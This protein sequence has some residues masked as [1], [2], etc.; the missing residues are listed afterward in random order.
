MAGSATA[1][2]GVLTGRVLDDQK[3]PLV[4]AN[5]FLLELNTG[6]VTDAEGE[7][8]IV[9]LPPGRYTLLVSFIGFAQIKQQVEIAEGQTRREDFILQPSVLELGELTVMGE[10]LKG[11]AKALNQQMSDDRIAVVVSADQLVRFPDQNIGDALKRLSAVTV[12]YDQGEARYAGI[13]G[14]DPRLNSVALDGERLPSPDA[15]TRAVQLDMISTDLIQSVEV[16]K[17]NTPD[18]DGDAIGGTVNLLTRPAV[19]SRRFNLSLGSGYDFLTGRG[20][21]NGSTTVGRRF[22]NEKLGLSLSGSIN[23]RRL[24]AHNSEGIWSVDKKGGIYASQWDI[25]RY[26]VRRLR[27]GVT[28]AADYRPNDENRFFL[29]LLL[30]Q[31]DDWE[32]RQRLRF[33]ME[34]PG[35]NDIAERSQ[36]YR[37][38]KGGN[39][40]QDNARL[41]QQRLLGFRL[42]GKHD[43]FSRWTIEWNLSHTRVTEERPHERYLQW[44]V[45]N[46]DV[47]VDL[48]SLRTPYFQSNTPDSLFKFEEMREEFRSVA[49]KDTR[50]SIDLRTPLI[51]KGFWKNT[52]QFGGKFKRLDKHNSVQGLQIS[53]TP[54]GKSEWSDMTRT[55]TADYTPSR[56]Y[57]GNYQLGRF[58]TPSFLGRLNFN[59]TVLFKQKPLAQQYGT[60]NYDAEENVSSAYAMLQQNIGKRLKLIFGARLEN[61]SVF[62]RGYEMTEGSDSLAPASGKSEYVHLLPSLH[63]RYEPG[64]RLVLR[65]AYSKSIARPD[66]YD[67]VPYR[68]LKR[69]GEVLR[70]G[71]PD[72]MPCRSHNWDFSIER[73]DQGVGLFSTGIFHKEIERFFYI[74]RENNALDPVTGKTVTEFYQPRNGGNGRLTGIELSGQKPLDFLPGLLSRLSFYMNYTRLFSAA[75]YPSWPGRNIPL[76]G[77]PKYTFNANLTYESKTATIGVSLSR[78]APYLDSKEIDLTPGLERWYDAVTFLDL[79]GSW[80]VSSRFGLFFEWNNLLNQP[81]RFYAGRKE[82]TA[83][84]EYFGPR[85]TFG[86]KYS[87]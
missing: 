81:L 37:Q 45:K 25:R 36:I 18:M 1:E 41:E 63:V 12:N 71:N 27:R 55:P 54:E 28:L 4:G 32:V 76:P 75:S 70:V 78:A 23:D 26:D 77:A 72:L 85:I 61:T 35:K 13:R 7:Y 6:D 87:L 66:F 17:N 33:R 83:Q 46:A 82:R 42:K 67:L 16:Y 11:Q 84:V 80:R 22:L 31:R 3:A 50:L 51:K 40:D 56:F 57:A 5:V 74:Y 14:L 2:G 53:L 30:N 20:L 19:F 10:H 44:W 9:N 43:W 38:T 64:H 47:V 48:S 39:V 73:Y 52:L 79:N 15:Q 8:R 86:C 49:E 58:T 29:N 69:A 34:P 59:D 62:Y 68:E 21:L 24:G 60:Q 65:A